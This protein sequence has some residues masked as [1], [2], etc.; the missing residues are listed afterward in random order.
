ME[1]FKSLDEAQKAF[2]KENFGYEVYKSGA[3]KGTIKGSLS[4]LTKMFI[5]AL[6]LR[7]DKPAPKK[8]VAKKKVKKKV[9]KKVEKKIE[10]K[11]EEKV[12]V[13]KEVTEKKEEVKPQKVVFHR[14]KPKKFNSFLFRK[15]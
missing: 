13:K 6:E 10:E 11:V 8:E 7:G 14:G 5:E 15:Q 12:E 2:E 4:S 9:E 3:N 1:K